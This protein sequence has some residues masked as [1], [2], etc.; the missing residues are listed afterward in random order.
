MDRQLL[1]RATENSD[2]PTPGYMYLDIAKN[3]ASNPQTCAEIAK[4]L[5]GRLASK[6]NSNIKHKCLKVIA[7]TAVSPY[8]RGQFKRC[9]SQDPQA[10]AAIKDATQ[11]RGPPDP[12]RGDEPYEK[13]RNAAKEALDA[14]YSDTPATDPSAGG[15]GSFATSISSSYGPSAGGG[16]G[17]APPPGGRRME[18]IGN[19]MFKDPRL[20][21]QQ[22]SIGNMT[23]NDIVNEA[24]STVIGMIK[25]PL[26][27]NVEV[28]GTNRQGSMSGPNSGAVSVLCNLFQD[29]SVSLLFI[30]LTLFSCYLSQQQYNRPPPGRSEI[31]HQTNG[32]WTMASN[33]GPGAVGQPPNYANDAG[34]YKSRDTP[35]SYSWAQKSGSASG[36]VGGAWASSPA[37]APN[38]YGHQATPSITVNDTGG[39]VVNA[40]GG[41]GTAVSDGSYERQLIM[42]LCPP[43]GMKP[44]P[45]PDKLAQFARLVSGL[46]ADLVCPVLLDCLEEGQPWIIRAKA[47]W[48][49][50]S[51]VQNG[52]KSEASNNPYADFFHAC[53]AEIA[54]LANHTRA[55]IR[56]PAKRVLNALGVATP[57]LGAAPL[58]ASAS[59]AA[60]APPAPVTNLLDFDDG[61]PLEAPPAAPPAAPPQ[62]LPPAAPA[63]GSSLFGGLNVATASS[64]APPPPA[65]APPVPAAPAGDSLFD[66]MSDGA[67]APPAAAVPVAPAPSSFGF[68]NDGEAAAAAVREVNQAS[69]MFDNLSLKSTEASAGAAAEAS[70][71]A[72]APGSAFGFINSAGSVDTSEK[73][74]DAPAAAMASPGGTASFDPLKNGTPTSPKKTMQFSQE[75]MQ[76]MYYQQ[77]MMQQ[78]M[79]MAQMQMALQQQA[80]RGSG[81]NQQMFMNMPGRVMQNPAAAKSTFAFMDKPQKEQSHSFDFVKD[82]MTNEKKK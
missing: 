38:A 29:R 35:N 28:Q 15:G 67:T 43:G 33:R 21:P 4:Y 11:F 71:A 34:Y 75:Q 60:A 10:M 57:V 18:G 79:Q 25:D 16:Y 49:M 7:K 54:P 19:P 37:A 26:A 3:A 36:G 61:A 77:M 30:C 78:Q 31:M 40:S 56:E 42:E 41:G 39:G 44:E 46:N 23:V 20:E 64:S 73:K 58:R 14:V 66:F 50:Q 17:G 12:V 51:C 55:A 63:S 70:L 8:L 1:A 5:T 65:A 69:S 53:S 6:N 62:E 13:V 2:A 32:E 48:V 76:A 82:A 27:R 9:L 68:M 24:K 47:L 81:G 22:P 80:K 72:V 45:P 59:P 52:K 74:T